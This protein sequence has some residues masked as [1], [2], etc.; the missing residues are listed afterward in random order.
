MRRQRKALYFGGDRVLF[1]STVT[2]LL[3]K[4]LVAWCPKLF[5]NSSIVILPGNG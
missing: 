3:S 4:Y 5:E 1:E 2:N